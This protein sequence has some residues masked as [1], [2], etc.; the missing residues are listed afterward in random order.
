MRA[1]V[2]TI[3]RLEVKTPRRKIRLRA[4]LRLE[5]PCAIRAEASAFRGIISKFEPIRDGQCPKSVISD[6]V[7]D[8]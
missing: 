1:V 2:C 5:S 4:L 3:A 8:Q 6:T 7:S